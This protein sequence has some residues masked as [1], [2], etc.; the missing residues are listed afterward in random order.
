MS[1][2]A[3]I[4]PPDGAR[5]FERER[6]IRARA[7]LLGVR[8]DTQGLEPWR[9]QPLGVI[10]RER[11]WVLVF[12][13]GAVV[14]LDVPEAERADALASVATRVRDPVPGRERE[15]VELVLE[16]NASRSVDDQGRIL[17]THPSIERIAVAASVLAKSVVLAHY[18][19]QAHH[20][21]ER[22]EALAERLRGRGGKRVKSDEL[23]WELGD[24]LLAQSRTIGRAEVAEKLELTWD[25][26]DV[27]RLYERLAQEYELADR[28]RVLLR[29][30]ELIDRT[31]TIYLELIRTRQSTRLEWYI[32]ALILV[33]VVLYVYDLVSPG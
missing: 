7:V 22:V 20:A 4:E 33:E 28:D 9:H 6:S 26:P 32:I 29:K 12:P 10:V 25:L 11:G 30:L 18:E 31:A 13:Y 3:R 1:E 15:E 21:M 8:I 24:A 5:L 2:A 23:L 27:D 14:L 19:E 17:L 16:P